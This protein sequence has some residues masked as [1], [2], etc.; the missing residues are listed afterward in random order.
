MEKINSWMGKKKVQ[1]AALELRN[2]VHLVKHRS[3]ITEARIIYMFHL[4][5]LHHVFK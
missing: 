1:G 5:E 2:F 4:G 3:N